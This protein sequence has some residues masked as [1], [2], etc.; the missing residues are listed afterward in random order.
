MQDEASSLSTEPVVSPGVFPRSSD[1]NRVSLGWTEDFA[2][3]AEIE[4]FS[5]LHSG[6]RGVVDQDKV[7]R[8]VDFSLPQDEVMEVDEYFELSPYGLMGACPRQPVATLMGDSAHIVARTPR[9][10]APGF[11]ASSILAPAPGTTSS[12][13]VGAFPREL[14]AAE[15]RMGRSPMLYVQLQ[16][17]TTLL[18]ALVDSGACDNF[19]SMQTV[20]YH[21]R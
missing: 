16:I 8:P 9:S 11:G 14:P 20:A 13:V 7:A 4:N 6:S 3:R 12:E 18:P 19:I 21:N 10:S 5:I 1:P 15:N 17:G 2:P